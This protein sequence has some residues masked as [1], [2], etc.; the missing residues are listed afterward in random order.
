[1]YK[2]INSRLDELQAA[3]L[4]VKLGKLDGD[5]DKRRV[6][7]KMYR[8]QI[9]NPKIILPKVEFGENN[10]VWHVFCSEDS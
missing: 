1:M 6:I 8:E 5:T 3:I 4:D 10:H 7:A 9:T 2:G